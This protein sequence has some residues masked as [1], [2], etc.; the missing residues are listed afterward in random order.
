MRQLRQHS[1]VLSFRV[2]AL[3][4]EAAVDGDW[5]GVSWCKF[6]DRKTVLYDGVVEDDVDGC[7]RLFFRRSFGLLD[8]SDSLPGWHTFDEN[9]HSRYLVVHF[10]LVGVRRL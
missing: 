10:S 7:H 8:G 9:G 2:V 4:S 5:F 6:F 1:K 3:F